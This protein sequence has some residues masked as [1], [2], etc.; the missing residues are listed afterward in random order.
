MT[1]TK[2]KL[3]IA[4]IGC[5]AISY[6]NVEA[7]RKSES[8]SLVYAVDINIASA[9]ALGAK[10]SVPFTDRL[11]QVLSA[12][13][14]DAVFICTPH[15]LH[16]LIAEQAA[17]AGKH[18]IVEKPMGANLSDSLRIV[19]S[20]KKAGVKLSVCYCMRYSRKIQ[21]ARQYIKNGGLGK[22]IGAQITMLRDQSERYLG[23]DI[24]QEGSINWHGVKAKSGGGLF[25]DNI[26]HYLDYYLYITGLKVD[27]ISCRAGAYILPTE[28]EDNLFA[29]FKCDNNAIGTIIAGFGVRG[30]GQEQN[31]QIGNALQRIW[32]KDGHILLIPRLEIFSMKR[33]DRFEPNR[34]H[35]LKPSKKYNSLGTGLAERKEFVERFVQAVIEDGKPDITGEDGLKVM[36][37]I[38]AAYRSSSLGKE[39]RI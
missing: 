19:E 4:I 28:V 23:H 14:V 9:Q 38:D 12:P 5:G 10:Y 36:A 35:V 7:I 15:Y 30:S 25:I 3:G 22:I 37:I 24:W 32:G 2:N 1:Y 39:T 13:E 33:I 26:A 31:N 29:L 6:A 16:A 21:F 34:W 20:C 8:A 18:V 11:E 17:E 27:S